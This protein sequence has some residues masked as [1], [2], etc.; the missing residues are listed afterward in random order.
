[1]R[2][3]RD[4][5]LTKLIHLFSKVNQVIYSSAPVSSASIKVLASYQVILLTRNQQRSD[6][7][8]EGKQFATQTP[9]S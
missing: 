3:R 4:V 9:K 6:Q 8:N 7:T 1:M 5:A 2:D